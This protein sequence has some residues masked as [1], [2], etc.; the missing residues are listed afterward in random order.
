MFFR[1]IHLL[2]I[3]ILNENHYMF[4]KIIFETIRFPRNLIVANKNIV[5]EL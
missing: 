3:R 1:L 2:N 4:V 5:S